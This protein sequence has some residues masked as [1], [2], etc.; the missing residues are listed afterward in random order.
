MNLRTKLYAAFGGCIAAIVMVSVIAAFGLRGVA[1]SGKE[2]AHNWLPSV[3]AL[4][5]MEVSVLNH[6]RYELNHV[7]SRDAE[8]MR[9]REARVKTEKDKFAKQLAV[10]EPLI[11]LDEERR[12]VGEVKAE[13]AKYYAESERVLSLSTGGKKDE[14]LALANGPIVAQLNAVTEVLEKLVAIQIK[15]ADDEVASGDAIAARSWIALLAIAVIG[16]LGAFGIA[17]VIVRSVQRQLGGDPS[18]VKAV[19]ERVGAGD[20][21]STIALADGDRD[22]VLAAMASMQARIQSVIDA[23]N[24]LSEAHEKG[25]TDHRIAVDGLPGS[26]RT[27]AGNVNALVESQ[28]EL[29]GRM[30]D[31]VQQYARGDFSAEMP[32][33]PGRKAEITRAVR[34][35]KAA[36][37]GVSGEID[38]LV[39][40]A[41]E[42]Q[43]AERGD[44]SRYTDKFR[45]M[46]ESLNRLMA[47]CQRGLEEANQ[48]YAA[49]SK[50]DLTH[51]IEGQFRGMFAEMQ[52]NAN[53]TAESLAGLV[54]RIGEASHS[55]GTATDEIAR[56]N[57]DLSSRTEEQASSLEET[58]SSMEE[59]TSTVKQNAESAKQANSLAVN[60]AE[61]ARAGGQTVNQAVGTMQGIAESSKRIQDII[62]VIDGI[63]FQT[64]IL[65]L[66][67]AVEAAR[68]GEQ[69]RGFAVVA[70][71]VR[72]LAQRSAA[73][74]KEIKE[75][76]TDSVARV[77]TGVAQ[78]S[79]AGS[80]MAEIVTAIQ[81][82]T[83][84]M[85]E[86]S[87]ASAEQS[88]GIEQVNTAVSGMDQMTQ[89]NAALVEEAA[90]AAES[91]KEQAQL[92]IAAVGEFRV[93]G[94]AR[95][96]SRAAAPSAGASGWDGKSER[97]GPNRAKNVARLGG[98]AKPAGS[99]APATA[100]PKRAAAGGGSD[101]WTEF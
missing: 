70:S 81:R 80:Q 62:T 22:S 67:A 31:V 12:L 94:A 88:A 91:L 15:G 9:Q 45:D 90:A 82:V 66:N 35:V 46:V 24:A 60:A 58:A 33:L 65:A 85:G 27:L 79:E 63:A 19:A 96:V 52:G 26:F 61:I 14:A 16:A 18:E 20:L 42:G 64:N 8:L 21:G 29:Q 72:N 3:K 38:R 78:V 48:M 89:Q 50:G 74:A 98:S 100:A 54:G 56:G 51:R 101:E 69:G 53:R 57:A 40:A 97:R 73:A 34:G 37:V 59:F 10:Y 86:I 83:D 5:E 11:V 17:W 30:L 7:M 49:L 25:N 32:E 71:E 41:A 13:L 6:R 93:D 77:D 1:A 92:L 43:F 55:I 2:V 87:S 4:L 95:A 99:A 47:E 75:L 68:A 76:I 28:L 39:D 23:Q 84:I 44:A 36:L